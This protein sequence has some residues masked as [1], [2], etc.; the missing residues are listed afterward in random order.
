MQFNSLYNNFQNQFEQSKNYV[1][2]LFILL[3]NGEK[4]TPLP[5]QCTPDEKLSSVFQKYRMKISDYINKIFI[6]E[7]KRLNEA[8][9]VAEAG[10]SNISKILVIDDKDVIGG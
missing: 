9:T 3:N 4:S 2:L 8:I 5:I 10:L 6:Y 1:T 7:S